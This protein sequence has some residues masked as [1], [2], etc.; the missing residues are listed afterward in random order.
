MIKSDYHMHTEFSGDSETPMED[1][2]VKSIELGLENICL[3]DHLDLEYPV[4]YGFFDLDVENYVRQVLIM[5]ERYKDKIN[6]Y[7][8]IEFGL[9]PEARIGKKYEELVN[10][11]DFDFILGSV[12]TINRKDPYFPD[13]WEGKTP[14]QG[15]REYFIEVLEN[16]QLYNEYDSLGHLDYIVRYANM[17]VHSPINKELII[18]NFDYKEYEEILDEILNHLITH[19]KSLEVNTAGYKYGLGAPNPQY[20]VLKRYKEMGGKLI[21]IGSDGH[22]PEHLAYDFDKVKELL[23]AVGFE[24]YVIYKDRKADVVKL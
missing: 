23:L 16:I 19:K 12:H 4:Q 10:K 22:K 6:I 7:L 2:I 9:M 13:Y 11:Y 1:Q 20:S 5:K 8:G 15:I 3:T 17:P 24:N 18:N 21:T 14:H